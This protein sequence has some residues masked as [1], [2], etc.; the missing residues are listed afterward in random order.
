MKYCFFILTLIGGVSEASASPLNYLKREIKRSG[1]ILY[2]NPLSKAGTGTLIGGSPKAMS[3]VEDPQTCFPDTYNESP[4][5]LRATEETN[6]GNITQTLSFEGKAGVD[7]M[8]FMNNGDSL[9]SV[10]AEFNTIQSVQLSFEGAKVER[11]NTIKIEDFYQTKMSEVCKKYLDKVGFIIQALKVDR[12]RYSF[13]DKNGMDIKLT[14]E[15][16]SKYFNIDAHVK[17]HIERDY[18]L[19]IDSPKYIGY[20][21]GRLKY[22]DQGVSLYRSHFTLFNR[23]IFKSIAIFQN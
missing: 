9:L 4:T 12:M 13:K 21:L 17:Y 3:I 23:Y 7:L 5:D 16:I 15:G 22:K 1:Y 20:Q 19:V 14:T 10:G 11:L 6:L 8:N 2:R 18:E